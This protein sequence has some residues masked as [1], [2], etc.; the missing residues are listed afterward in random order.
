MTFYINRFDSEDMVH[1]LIFLVYMIQ[2]VFLGTAAHD[3]YT[4]HGEGFFII[5]AIAGR[6]LTSLVYIFAAWGSRVYRPIMLNIIFGPLAAAVFLVIS[7]PFSPGPIRWGLWILAAG[8]EYALQILMP[9]LPRFRFAAVNIEH[10]VERF[11]L[12]SILVMGEILIAITFEDTGAAALP[13]Y[14]VAVG[15]LAFGFALSIIYFDADATSAYGTHAIR[16]HRVRGTQWW[17]SHFPAQISMAASGPAIR[18]VLESTILND[19]G[20][21]EHL[22]A[23]SQWLLGGSC[24]LAL[25]SLSWIRTRHRLSFVHCVNRGKWHSRSV[26]VPLRLVCSLI[27][28][29]TG[30]F[31]D[32]VLSGPTRMWIIAI[33]S[34][35]IAVMELATNIQIAHILAAEGKKAPP[36]GSI[37]PGPTPSTVGLV[38]DLDGDEATTTTV[39]EVSNDDNDKSSA[40]TSTSPPP[41]AAPSPPAADEKPAPN[42]AQEDEAPPPS[43]NPPTTPRPTEPAGSQ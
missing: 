26:Q 5:T 38:N 16:Y 36:P 11:G 6:M 15:G 8:W 41:P 3:V 2:V 28:L 1:R 33:A 43:P 37:L 4:D 39:S 10:M 29:A 21:T 7:L 12:F 27:P 23:F 19:D 31:D 42:S 18:A 20:S 17:S 22:S 34:G 9:R 24:S 35:V 25:L 32:S 13:P 14:M 30:F 40:L